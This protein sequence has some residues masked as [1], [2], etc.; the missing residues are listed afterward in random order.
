MIL[1]DCDDRFLVF[2]PGFL[3]SP[4][5]YRGLLTRIAGA[6]LTVVVPRLYRVGPSVMLGRFT[7][8]DE[9]QRAVE[10]VRD[11]CGADARMWLAGHSRGGQAAWLAARLLAEQGLVVDGLILVDPV[12]GAGPR[13]NEPHATKAPVQFEHRPL[14]IGAGLGGKCAP[15]AVNH[16]QFA[17]AADPSWHVVVQDM[18]HADMLT[19]RALS[20]GRRLCGGGSDPD[21][22]RA[23]IQSMVEDYLAGRIDSTWLPP[24]GVAW[25]R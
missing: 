4:D 13:S 10:V 22:S 24:S 1:G 15:A 18:G 11:R 19:G 2:L 14:I 7:A 6:D 9:A 5:A 21:S 25:A 23:A 20:L 12:D 8:D 17:R 3:I 16:D